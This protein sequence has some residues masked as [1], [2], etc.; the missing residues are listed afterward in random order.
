MSIRNDAPC[1]IDGVCPY[2][3]ESNGDCEYWC[4]A[5]SDSYPWEE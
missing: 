2:N 5:E 1:D 3:A 4:S